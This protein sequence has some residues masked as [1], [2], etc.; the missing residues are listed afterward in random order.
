LPAI[1]FTHVPAEAPSAQARSRSS[2]GILDRGRGPF[3]R[4]SSGLP[5]QSPLI[6]SVNAWPYPVEPW[7]S[8]KTT[9]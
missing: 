9:P 8:M 5:P 2:H 1:Q 6:E 7:K 3:C 4:S